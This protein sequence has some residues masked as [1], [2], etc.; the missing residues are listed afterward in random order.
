MEQQVAGAFPKFLIWLIILAFF[1][2]LNETVFNVSLPDISAQFGIEPSAANWVNTSF[3]LSF[4]A[5]TAVYGKIA[6]AF[7]VKRLLRFGL[8]LYAGG[9]MAGLLLHTWFPGLL[10]ARFIQGVGA[11]VVPG[12]I[13]VIVATCVDHRHRGKAFG[14]IG[15][16][17]ALGEGIGPVL[18]GLIA[19]FV[20]WSYLFV[21]PM[22]TLVTLPFFMRTLPDT[23]SKKAPLDVIGGGLLVLGIVSFS[24][25]MT[26]YNWLYGSASIILL[27]LFSWRIRSVKEPFIDPALFKKRKFIVGV[28]LGGI[29]LGIVAGFISMVPYMMREVYQMTTS[30][31]GGGVLF[32][33]TISVILFGVAGGNWVDRRGAGFVLVTGIFLLGAGF[34]IIALLTDGSPW[35]ISGALILIFGGLSFVKTVISTTVAD[36]L[37][38]DETGSG[39]GFLNYACFLAEGIGIA[40]V[41]GMLVQHSLDLRIIPTITDPRAYLYSNLALL[42]LGVL[43][44]CGTVFWFTVRR[45][46]RITDT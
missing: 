22:I 16:T 44:V 21:L 2:V 32:P 43:M 34:L 24:L 36:A 29:L 39:M 23:P 12:L 6:D 19:D 5:G 7:G 9:S 46:K 11:S 17:V 30:L 26:N 31:I 20:H 14:L 28:L 25:F 15:S 33:G 1:S 38:S 27:A 4:A 45:A 18:G 37:G 3:M 8:C 41:G 10:L 40:V 13:V 42:L 35:L